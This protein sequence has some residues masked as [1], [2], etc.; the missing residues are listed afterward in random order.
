MLTKQYSSLSQAL[1]K[2]EVTVC[3]MGCLFRTQVTL[4]G[5]NYSILLTRKPR[6]ERQG[7]WPESHC[8]QGRLGIQGPL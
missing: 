8:V 1:I 7:S 3:R 5:Q 6:R 2:K 4:G